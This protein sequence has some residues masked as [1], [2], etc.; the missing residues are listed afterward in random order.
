MKLEKFLLAT[1]AAGM[2]AACSSD[3]PTPGPGNE[4]MQGDGYVA[5]TINLPTTPAS[6]RAANDD[7]NDGDAKE[8]QVNSG[9]LLL[10]AGADEQS[11]VFKA[12]YPLSLPTPEP[13]VD[14]DNITTS[15]LTAVKV[16]KVETSENLYGLVM[17]NYTGVIQTIAADGSLNIYTEATGNDTE[18]FAGTFAQLVAK[19]SKRAFYNS[20]KDDFF[21]TNA[22]LSTVAGGT[23]GTPSID[24][25]TTLVSLTNSLKS[26]EEEAKAAPAGSFF[27]ERAVAKATLSNEATE[28]VIGADKK[29]LGIVGQASWLLDNTEP[30]S[31]IVRNM[32][33]GS[34]MGFANGNRGRRFAGTTVMGT[35]SI[36]PAEN[37]FRTYWCIDPHYTVLAEGETLTTATEFD[38]NDFIAAGTATEKSAPLYCHENTFT[39]AAQ[40]KRHTTRAIIKVAY[41][42]NND[43]QAQTFYTVNGVE[44]ELYSTAA[45]A[46]SYSLAFILNNDGIKAAIKGALAEGSSVAID[47]SNYADYLTITFARDEND[48]YRKVTAIKFKSNAAFET[49]P[50]WTAEQEAALIE[51]TNGYYRIA[52]YTDGENFYDIR[53]KHFAGADYTDLNDLAPWNPASL[54][55][56]NT[57]STA[58][59][60]PGAD[61]DN[62]WL[63]RYGMVRNNWYDVTISGFK[64]LGKPA[65][66]SLDVSKDKTPDDEKE[67]EQWIAFKVNILSWA[68]RTQKHEF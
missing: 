28:A 43:G 10:F 14:N 1:L 68:L 21:M 45:E 27:V 2:F 12:A 17:L 30:T 31:F 52:E 25:V 44:E 47:E 26:T 20:A 39:T 59:A 48:G 32:G 22:P 55:S 3:E 24:N 9:A 67:T 18:A 49:T 41:S 23:V 63:G 42:L 11:A 61:A 33:D 7:F 57:P 6:S 56:P 15:Y 62:N 65:P 34:Y 36:Q 4:A 46:E 58:E 29:K 60:Y 51:L 16:A 64:H 53:F 13:D 40:D 37:L 19:T 35:T 50:E 54:T 8:Y 66:G 38:D 5:V